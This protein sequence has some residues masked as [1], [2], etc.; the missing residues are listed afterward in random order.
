[1]KRHLFH[2]RSATYPPST[3]APRTKNKGF[4]VPGFL[5]PVRE[6][7]YIERVENR[8]EVF[9]FRICSRKFAE[10]IRLRQSHSIVIVTVVDPNGP[11]R[12][13]R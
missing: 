4:T 7:S 10:L 5:H 12:P 8:N 3:R 13:V 9:D 6:V 1:M 11:V 2:L